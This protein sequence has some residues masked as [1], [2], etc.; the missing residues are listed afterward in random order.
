MQK[1]SFPVKPIKRRIFD[2]ALIEAFLFRVPD[3][4]NRSPSFESRIPFFFYYSSYIRRFLERNNVQFPSKT[5]EIFFFFF[6]KWARRFNNSFRT[7]FQTNCR[8]KCSSEEE[9]KKV[10]NVNKDVYLSGQENG[11]LF[12]NSNHTETPRNMTCVL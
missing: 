8:E 6:V 11:I 3:T 1:T 5:V 2:P 10:Q 9:I 4:E 12:H 7:L